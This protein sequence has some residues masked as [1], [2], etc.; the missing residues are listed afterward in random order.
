MNDN[1]KCS[2]YVM[3]NLIQSLAIFTLTNKNIQ[4][5]IISWPNDYNWDAYENK[6]PITYCFGFFQKTRKSIVLRKLHSFFNGNFILSSGLLPNQ[7]GWF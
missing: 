1:L 4:I 2:K 7:M 3:S 5:R 6:R